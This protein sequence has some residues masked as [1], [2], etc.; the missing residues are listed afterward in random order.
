MLFFFSWILLLAA[1]SPQTDGDF[2]TKIVERFTD[3]GHISEFTTYLAGDR[4]RTE[5]DVRIRGYRVG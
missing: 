4:R 5:S 1:K 2:G 3:G